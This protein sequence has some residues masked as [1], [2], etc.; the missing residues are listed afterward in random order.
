MV[1]LQQCN[2][3]VMTQKMAHAH[4]ENNGNYCIQPCYLCYIP[5]DPM[6]TATMAIASSLSVFV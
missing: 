4:I 6:G 1:S 2:A 5:L 3:R